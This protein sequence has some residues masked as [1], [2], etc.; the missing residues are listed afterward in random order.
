[1][2]YHVDMI[3]H[4]TAFGKPVGSTGRDRLI[5]CYSYDRWLRIVYFHYHINMITHGT[6][7]GKP[8]GNTGE[9]KLITCR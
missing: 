8:I 2:H 1:M 6:A 5:T 9:D 3:T 7:F 4:G